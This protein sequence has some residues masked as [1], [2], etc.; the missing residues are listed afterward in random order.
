MAAPSDHSRGLPGP[1][2][3]AV[4]VTAV[5]TASPGRHRPAT[6]HAVSPQ[7]PPNLST[8]ADKAGRGKGCKTE[9]KVI[10]AEAPPDCQPL[11]DLSV[12]YGFE[13]SLRQVRMYKEG[14]EKVLITT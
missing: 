3:A 12:L 5:T 11:S 8:L 1:L 14:M 2:T 9:D 13:D 4:R 7:G 6:G 10:K